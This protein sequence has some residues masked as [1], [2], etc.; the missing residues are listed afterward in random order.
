VKT[1]REAKLGAGLYRQLVSS[2]VREFRRTR[3]ALRHVQSVKIRIADSGGGDHLEE[4][5][6]P[7]SGRVTLRSHWVEGGQPISWTTVTVTINGDNYRH[8]DRS[9]RWA[10]DQV[11]SSA[12]SGLCSRLSR[13]EDAM[14][15]FSSVL[16]NRNLRQLPV[17]RFTEH[18]QSAE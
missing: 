10:H 8:D 14:V 4:V 11:G 13:G 18:R 15:R 1:E 2:G 17:H 9:H 3:E 6:C 12:A 7:A 16:K 5:C